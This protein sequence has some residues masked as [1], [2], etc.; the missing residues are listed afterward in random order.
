MARRRWLRAPASPTARSPHP[1]TCLP[2]RDPSRKK[3]EKERGVQSIRR[4]LT[5]RPREREAK[6]PVPACERS[7]EVDCVKHFRTTFFC[8]GFA[9]RYRRPLF[10]DVNHAV[11]A[12]AALA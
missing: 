9:A 5:I 8:Q 12:I 6:C 11:G 7:S 10:R 3:E 2:R 1:S 4:A